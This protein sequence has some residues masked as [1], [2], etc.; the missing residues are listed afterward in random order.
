MTPERFEQIAELYGAALELAPEERASLIDSACGADEEL[1]HEVESLLEAHEQAGDFIATPALGMAAELLGD[2]ESQTLAAGHIIGHYRVLSLLGAGGMGKVYLAEDTMLGRKV[3]LKLLPK[4]FT[5]D[6]ERVQRFELE[7]RAASALNH[8]NILTIHE[9]GRAGGVYFIVTEFIEGETLRAHMAG[10]RMRLAEAL[11]A[12]AQVASALDV[13]HAEGVVHR[14]IKPENV[15][16]RRDRIVKVLDFGLTKLIEKV[17]PAAP[18]RPVG[19]GAW[20]EMRSGAEP[21]LVLGTATY[22]SPEQTRNSSSVDHRTDLWSLGV[23]LYEMVAGRP[24]FEGKDVHRRINSIRQSEPSPLAAYAEGTP[25]RFEEIVRKALAKD[26]DERYQAARDLLID[27]RNLKRNLEVS[28]EIAL[29]SFPE[30]PFTTG[31]V[32]GNSERLAPAGAGLAPQ[33]SSSK[34]ILSEIIRHKRGLMVALA[35]ITLLTAGAAFWAYRWLSRDRHF[36]RASVPVPKIILFTSFPGSEME[37]SFSPD[38]RQIAFTWNG[39]GANNYDV[40]VKRLDTGAQLRLTSHPSDDR[41]PCWSPDGRHI[42]FIRF[43]ENEDSIALVPTTG[44]P[45][46]VLHSGAPP[47][48]RL[49]GHSLAWSSDGKSLAFS[50]RDSP[51]APSSV[52]LLSIESLERRKLTSPPAGSYGDRSPAISPDGATLVFIRRN[53]NDTDN[54]YLVRV[55]GGEPTRLTSDNSVINGLAWTPDGRGIIYSSNR[56]GSRRLWKVPAEGGMPE[57]VSAGEESPDT[58]TISR[59]GR[60]LAYAATLSDRN[61]WR[62]E[63]QGVKNPGGSQAL[64]LISSTRPD[65]SPQYSSDGKKIVFVSSRTGTAELWTCDADG[66]TPVRLTSFG[67]SRLGSPRWSPDGRQI[68]FDSPAEGSHDIYVVGLDGGRPR[69]LMVEPSADVRPSWSRDGRFIYFG[70]ER[71]GEWQIWK[72]PAE[73]GQAIQVTRQGGREA[74]ESPD[75][76]FVYYAKWNVPGLWRAPAEG[77]EEVKVLDHVRHG[78]WAVWEQGVYFVNPEARP[79]QS[80][81]FYS[82]ATGRTTRVATIE[83]EPLWNGPNL[84]TTSDGRWILYVQ[85]DQTESDII[86]VENFS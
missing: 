39:P 84:T 8:P 17:E 74:F 70:S 26:P 60:L 16:V 14:D 59:Q 54:I 51:L 18:R 38:S 46:R 1:R 35:V 3:A 81:E 72:A 29:S 23:M 83:K 85:V 2:V 12:A 80:V 78:A 66:S 77:G 69:R 5:D 67:G 44:G 55:S 58:V 48:S 71:S 33:I 79:H 42:A 40:Y 62:V 7:A 41:Y 36:D 6:P 75:G 28:E 31:A 30:W 82:F 27:L 37:P 15:M 9:F 86:L 53:N 64:K 56:G 49:P 32:N 43:M 24:P 22:M 68:A 4:E 63:S 47:G 57:R 13:A 45:E 25:E 10:G 50:D 19:S 11:D 65:D 20:S 34:V 21:G 73:G 52:Y 61:I 76:K